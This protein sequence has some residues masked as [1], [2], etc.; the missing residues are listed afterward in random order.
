VT[1]K[2]D[3]CHKPI[4]EQMTNERTILKVMGFLNHSCQNIADDVISENFTE[5]KN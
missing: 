1:N 3:L 4:I 5:V 2:K